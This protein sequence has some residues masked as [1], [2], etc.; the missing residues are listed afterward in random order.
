M[1]NNKD[2][3][4][5]DKLYSTYKCIGDSREFILITEDVKKVESQGRYIACPY[6]GC[7]KVRKLKETD[8]FKE[9]MDSRSYKRVRGAI[10]EVK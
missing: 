8:S 6:C 3:E 5:M 9:C 4:D 2:G 1:L 10:I 7:R